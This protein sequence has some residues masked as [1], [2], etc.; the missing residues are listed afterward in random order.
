MELRRFTDSMAFA[1]RAEPYLVRHEAAH[2]L[3]LGI[4]GTLRIDPGRFVEPLYLATVEEGGD[5][6]AV[7][8]RTPPFNVILSLIAPESAGPGAL[9]LVARDVRATAGDIPGVIGPVPLSHIFSEGWQRLTGRPGTLSMRERAYSLDTVTPVMG[10]PGAPRRATLADRE[11]LMRWLVAFEREALHGSGVHEPAT[12]V[13]QVLNAPER[14]VYLWEDER[15]ESVSLVA[16]GNPTPNGMRVGPVYTPPE[17]RGHGYAS[18]LT[19]AVSQLL[20]DG[21]RRFV[22]LFTNLDNPTS[23][24]IYQQIGY[25]PVC[26]VDVYTF[27]S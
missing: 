12:W 22:F 10:V 24:K 18:A 16:Y 20:L 21:G 27:A 8:I 3:P 9:A 2:S 23:N 25:R 7:A 11:L 13:E 5:V 4:L 1:T 26:D 14:G 19:A 6:V 17:Q 15:G